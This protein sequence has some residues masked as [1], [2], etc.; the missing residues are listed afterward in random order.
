M[1]LKFRSLLLTTVASINLSVLLPAQ[2][3]FAQAF[4]NLIFFGDSNTDSGI[5]AAVRGVTNSNAAFVAQYGA[6][7]NFGAYTTSPGRM[8]SVALGQIYGVT[9]SPA[10]S[11][12]AQTLGLQLAGGGNNYAVGGAR[13]TYTDPTNPQIWSAASQ[14]SAYLNSTGGAADRNALYTVYIGINDLKTTTTG[15]FGNIVNP[16]NS[17]QLQA[18]AQ[19]VSA[20]PLQL[21]QAGARY[22]LVPNA[23]SAQSSA[24][25][26]AA[27]GVNWNSTVNQSL[28]YYTQTLWNNLAT[29]NVNFIPA[30]FNNVVGY[31]L[32][33]P[34]QYGFSV[35][36]INTP[37][38]GLVFAPVCSPANWVAP[39]ADSTYVYAD[40]MGHLTS[41]AQKILADYTYN[42]LA[43]P[44]QISL[45]PIS[46][47]NSRASVVN[48]IRTQIPDRS[49]V[50]GE[51]HAWISGD[52]TRLRNG[53]L[54]DRD[55][56]KSVQPVSIAAGIDYQVAPQ[57]LAGVSA[58][59]SRAAQ[60]YRNGGS[61]DSDDVAASF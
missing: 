50:V 32:T 61:F 27:A 46:Q 24:S 36:S 52:V 54:L 58:S 16:M 5:N 42:L 48:A 39:M 49:R 53:D 43:A 17:S 6:V 30:D 19:Q 10:A 21:K 40:T 60:T 29:S 37:A 22:I 3:V 44:G 55:N 12:L 9:V 13:V 11:V 33:H 4:T 56:G 18:L 28:S 57:W 47:I 35:T 7:P 45:M 51:R 25:A 14:V 31:I 59:F 26:A 34:S 2:P 41:S 1:N 8:W 15:G 23:T 38:C 20:L